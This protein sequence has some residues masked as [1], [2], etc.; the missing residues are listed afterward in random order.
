MFVRFG[1]T[2]GHLQA[3]QVKT[4][5]SNGKVHHER[6][7]W[8]GPAITDTDRLAFWGKLHERPGA[9]SRRLDDAR[10][11]IPMPTLDDQVESACEDARLLQSI[12][13]MADDDIACSRQADETQRHARGASKPRDPETVARVRGVHQANDAA[14]GLMTI[15]APINT[16]RGMQPLGQGGM[17]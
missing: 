1:T 8:I 6:E 13:D 2:T 11:G 5:R 16:K 14:A 17:T 12:A 10:L 4:R 15:A 9:L 7:P 3:S